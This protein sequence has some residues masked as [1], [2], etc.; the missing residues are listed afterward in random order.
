MKDIEA[1]TK[2]TQK[3]IPSGYKL[4]FDDINRIAGKEGY[5]EII[6]TAWRLGFE[7]AYRAAKAGRLDFQK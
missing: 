4:K 7:S 2:N 3:H 1:Y 5:Y 6:V